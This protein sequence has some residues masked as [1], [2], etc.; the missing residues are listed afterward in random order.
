MVELLKPLPLQQN[1]TFSEIRNSAN[2]ATI[3]VSFIFWR[4]FNPNEE[5]CEI[6]FFFPAIILC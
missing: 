6:P 1:Y 4:A 5:N 2:Y 3:A